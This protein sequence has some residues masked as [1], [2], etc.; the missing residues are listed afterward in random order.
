MLHTIKQHVKK[1]LPRRAL[2]VWQ[3]RPWRPE[4]TRAIDSVLPDRAAVLRRHI[5]S[6][7]RLPNLLNPQTYN[8]K[9]L[10]R[11]LFDRRDV[12]TQM[13]DKYAVRKYVADRLG[14]GILPQVYCVT[15]DPAEIP[16]N[17]LPSRFV[18][19]ATHGSGWVRIVHDKSALDIDELVVTCKRWLKTS[20]Y[21]LDYE[22]PYR[23]V[24][25]RLM[26][27]EFIDDGHLKS[28]N[29]YKLLVYDGHV[30]F[31]Q[32]HTDRL[33]KRRQAL[34]TRDWVK[35]AVKHGAPPILED[36]PRPKHLSQM[37]EAAEVLA[38]EI[39][40][41]RVDLYDTADRIYFG[42]LTTTPGC[43]LYPFYPH[44]FDVMLGAPWHLPEGQGWRFRR[45]A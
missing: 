11:I 45:H 18:V 4:I 14:S 29:D 7:H 13:T 6:H 8:E 30:H 42:E 9:V 12:L 17:E 28:P 23:N 10:H 20:Y 22:W 19:K 1:I 41:V 3:R 25:P 5:A 34:F 16:F 24:V 44:E 31:V 21:S 26:V 36:V 39:E 35:Q 15:S 2:D 37:I 43:G 32:V 33:I 38:K 27:E 40:F